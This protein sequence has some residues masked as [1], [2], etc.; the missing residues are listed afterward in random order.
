MLFPPRI[1]SLDIDYMVYCVFMA[2]E[3]LVVHAVSSDITQ[4]HRLNRI[5]DQNVMHFKY[6]CITFIDNVN[7]HFGN[8]FLYL[9]IIILM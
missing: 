4:V 5:K 8:I 1:N 9:F 2:Q 3:E 6:F 7:I